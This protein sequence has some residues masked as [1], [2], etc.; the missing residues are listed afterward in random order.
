[1]F[2]LETKQAICCIEPVVK[3]ALTVVSIFP[4]DLLKNTCG[5]LLASPLT[6]ISKGNWGSAGISFEFNE[7]VTDKLLGVPTGVV[8]L[9]IIVFVVDLEIK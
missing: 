9:G 5:V 1:M 8:I 3:E 7:P 2:L 6:N 4:S